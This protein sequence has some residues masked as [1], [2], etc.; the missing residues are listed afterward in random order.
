MASVIESP[1]AWQDE[2]F[3]ILKE[4]GVRQIAYVPDAGHSH[5]IRRVHGDP[6]MRGVVLTSF[7]FAP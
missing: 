1:A 7:D 6:E 2:I 4:G 3:T 5:V